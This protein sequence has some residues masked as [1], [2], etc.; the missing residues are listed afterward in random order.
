MSNELTTPKKTTIKGLIASDDFKRQVALCLPKHLTPDRFVRVAITAITRAPKLME[1]EQASLLRCL[2]DCSQYGIEPDGRRA[3]LIPF[4]N[5]K[6]GVTE[7]QL[8]IDYKGLAELAMRSGFLAC[9][10]HADIVC[11]N[12]EFEVDL[13]E[14]VK[15]RINYREPRG[16]A[17]A[18][19]AIAKFKDGAKACAVMTMEEVAAIRKRSRAANS[20]P[21]VTD[22]NEMAK[23]TV[24]RRLAKMLPL[25]PEFRD[26]ADRDDDA[27]DTTATAAAPLD[28][29][30]SLTERMLAAP[31]EE[32]EPADETVDPD[33][34]ECADDELPL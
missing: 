16:K 33:T 19:Y 1:C 32:P 23:K 14:V 13:G 24:F 25:S 9:A 34:G 18:V 6:R 10:P 17:Y 11:E 28:S 7:C 5:R 30:D 3:H 22:F 4:E 29:L 2:M 27:I 15:H 12:D 8:I 31:E 26:A 21:W 20:G